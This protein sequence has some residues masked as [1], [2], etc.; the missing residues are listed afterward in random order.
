M[1]SL[2]QKQ[3]R[4]TLEKIHLKRWIY[5]DSEVDVVINKLFNCR[6]QRR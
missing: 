2:E 4:Q 3:L 6:F 5:N 1:N